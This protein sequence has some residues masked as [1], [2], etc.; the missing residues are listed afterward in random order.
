VASPSDVKPA[1]TCSTPYL[2]QRRAAVD[3]DI[4]PEDVKNQRLNAPQETN[5]LESGGSG[6]G[7]SAHPHGVAVGGTSWLVCLAGRK[8]IA[9]A[10]GVAVAMLRGQSWAP[11]PSSGSRVNVGTIPPVPTVCPTRATAGKARRRP[12][13]VGWGGGPVVVGGRKAGHMAK[14]PSVFAAEAKSVEVAGE[15]RRTVARPGRGR[16]A[17]TCDAD[18]AAPMGDC[19][20]WP[21]LR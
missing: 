10:C 16:A 13:L 19:R 11:T 21:L 4:C 14:G 6:L 18:E 12:M 7:C 17:G 15:H 3:G 8:A 5:Q 1:L 20:S 9:K 2:P